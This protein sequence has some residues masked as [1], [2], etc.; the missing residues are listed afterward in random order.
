MTPQPPTWLSIDPAKSSGVARWHGTQLAETLI[1]KPR[2][3]KGKWYAGAAIHESR[4]EAWDAVYEGVRAVV[5]ERGFGGMAAAVR[6]QGMHIGWHQ[7]E[8]AGRN[9]PDPIEIN[10]S[11]W[12]R[13]IKEMMGVSFPRDSKRCKALSVQ[14]ACRQYGRSFGEDEADAVLLGLAAMRMGLVEGAP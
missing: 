13:V 1:V 10:V 3:G 6:S 11:E 14:L 8:C 12:R 5:I 2:G 7:R 9:M 4:I